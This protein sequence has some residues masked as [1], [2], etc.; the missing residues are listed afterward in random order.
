MAKAVI[1]IR[2]AKRFKDTVTKQ[3]TEETENQNINDP[4]FDQK[5]AHER[6]RKKANQTCYRN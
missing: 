2:G 3:G 6:F 5:A 4:D 1:D